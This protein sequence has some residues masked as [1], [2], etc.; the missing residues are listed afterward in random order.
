MNLELLCLA[1]K[2]LA[3]SKHLITG[4]EGNESEVQDNGKMDIEEKIKDEE[5]PEADREG[6]ESE[7]SITNKVMEEKVKTRKARSYRPR[8]QR[9]RRQDNENKDMEEKSKDEESQKI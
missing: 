7:C 5:A 3:V 2:S 4:L 6:N 8:R 9:I 1:K